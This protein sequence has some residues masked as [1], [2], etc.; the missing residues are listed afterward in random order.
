MRRLQLLPIVSIVH[1]TAVVTYRCTYRCTYRFTRP[2]PTYLDY[3]RQITL[4]CF[5]TDLEVPIGRSYYLLCPLLTYRCT[6][7]CTYRCAY[8]FA[9]R[10]PLVPNPSI[11]LSAGRKWRLYKPAPSL[12]SLSLSLSLSPIPLHT[13]YF[14]PTVSSPSLTSP[15]SSPS[16]FLRPRHVSSLALSASIFSRIFGLLR[17][18]PAPLLYNLLSCSID[19]RS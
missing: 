3:C 2:P 7:R 4:E 19:V 10:S 14:H 13:T 5:S 18:R 11:L 16:T 12:P 1:C 17:F 9:Y 15:S 8:R 6:N